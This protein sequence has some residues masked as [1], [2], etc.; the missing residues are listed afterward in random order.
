MRIAVC[1]DE[2]TFREEIKDAVYSYSDTH[3]LEI[4]IEE[5][6]NGEDLLVS[7]HNYEIIFLDIKMAGINGLETARKLRENGVDSAIFFLTGFPDYM[8]EAF[9][10][11]TFRFFK[12]PLDTEKLNK[13]LD[14]FFWHLGESHRVILRL[15]SRIICVQSKDI[16]YLEADNKK[17]FVHFIN[18]NIHVAGTMASVSKPLSKKDFVKVHKSYIVNLRHINKHDYRLIYFE[19]NTCVPIGRNCRTDFINAFQIYVNNRN[20]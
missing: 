7:K 4:V 10:V 11:R 12:K 9:E 15:K 18:N 13:S 2:R 6:E 20:I 1:D 3:R 19:H 16:V 5:F 14:D 17:C 8:D